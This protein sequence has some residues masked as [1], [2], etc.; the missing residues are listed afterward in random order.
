MKNDECQMSVPKTLTVFGLWLAMAFL[1]AGS[2]M[3]CTFTLLP[4]ESF[5]QVDNNKP[6]KLLVGTIIAPPFAMK[7][8]EGAWEGLSIA[9]WQ[10]VASLLD[11]QY[12]MLKYNT[13]G[14]LVDAVETGKLDVI[15]GLAVTE[16]R[17]IALDLS[18][19]YCRSGLAIAVSGDSAGRGWVDFAGRMDI[20]GILTVIGLLILLWLIAGATVWVFEGRRN[21]EMFGGGPIKGLGHAV[22]WAAVTMTTVGYGDKAPKTFGG[23]IVAIV[24]MLA[25]IVLISS[26]TASMSASLTAEKLVGKVRGLHD[27]AHVRV[28]SM[29]QSASLKWL[30]ERG[31]APVPFLTEQEG[32]QA[33]V[34]NKIDAFVND[35]LVLKYIVKTDFPGRVHVLAGTF[36]HYYVS[37]G[38][39]DGSP[40]REPI[41][42]ALLKIMEKDEWN[43]MT[44]FVR[45]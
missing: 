33:I 34:D 4:S 11:I 44:D 29:A 41:N 22:W 37:M 31:I 8:A 24:W 26:F 13:P 40:L 30:A 1:I 21:R 19:S 38:M 23:R 25:S 17:E 12:E 2:A 9:L 6:A 7:T 5:A 14:Q 20:S 3:I 43:R 35:E 45:F 10:A 27:L 18:H 32:L 16:K 15:I 42:R 28:G 39:P 36:D